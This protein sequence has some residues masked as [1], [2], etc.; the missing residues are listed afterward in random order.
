MSEQKPGCRSS[1]VGCVANAVA[2]LQNIR[3]GIHLET[4]KEAAQQVVDAA[5]VRPYEDDETGS[6]AL[7][8]CA[9]CAAEALLQK[10]VSVD[11]KIVPSLDWYSL[12][13]TP[14]QLV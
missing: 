1:G 10:Y 4:P 2:L 14:D 3:P 12:A 7:V 5:I 13:G 8:H 9:N 11:D 6:S